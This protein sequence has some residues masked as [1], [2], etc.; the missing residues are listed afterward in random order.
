MAAKKSQVEKTA[1]SGSSTKNKGAGKLVMETL[2]IGETNYHTT[3]TRKFKER[4]TWERPDEKEVRAFIP[5]TVR[6][7]LVKKGQKIEE[8]DPLL[9]IEAMKMLNN[10]ASPV[11]GVIESISVSVNEQVAKNSLLLTF[12]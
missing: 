12:K 7:I 4:K 9:K 2:L 11:T 5:G 1:E 8:G 10:V 3:L 6:A